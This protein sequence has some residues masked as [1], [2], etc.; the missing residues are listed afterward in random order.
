M[1]VY[2]IQNLHVR[3]VV[4][5]HALATALFSPCRGVLYRT[6]TVNLFAK[7]PTEK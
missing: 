6:T 2:D 7:P 1:I 5:N 3:Y 4:L